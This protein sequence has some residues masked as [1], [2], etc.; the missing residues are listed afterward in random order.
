MSFYD[1]ICR[2]CRTTSASYKEYACCKRKDILCISCS[3][4]KC[5]SCRVS[6]DNVLVMLISGVQVRP[7][8][9]AI[10]EIIQRT[11]GRKKQEDVEDV[12]IKS[13]SLL[14]FFNNQSVI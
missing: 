8:A 2:V 1:P 7:K 4:K 13:I 10:L 6:Q 9:I 14:N 5:S 3:L 12:T 11:L